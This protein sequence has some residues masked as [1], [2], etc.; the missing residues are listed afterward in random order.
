MTKSVFKKMLTL[1]ISAVFIKG[2]GFFFRIYLSKVAG[3]E[4]CGLYHLVLSV[5][6]LMA[7]VSS[8]GINQ[9]LSRLVAYNEKH[10]KRILK[11]ALIM[12]GIISTIVFLTVFLNARYIAIN[13]L[14]DS[15]VVKS[16][17]TVAFSFPAIAVFSSVAGY[18]NGLTKV[19]FASH[20]QII[21][22]IIRIIFVMLFLKKGMESGLD[23]GIL[24]LSFGIVLGEYISAM[25]I[26]ISYLIFS[27]NKKDAY[28]KRYF[29]KD[30]LKISI[31]VAS[32]GYISSFLH[33]VENILLREKLVLSGLTNSQS[34]SILGLAKGM[35]APIIFF[36]A[37]ITN[38][39]T[40]LTLPKISKEQ[41]LRNYK[42]IKRITKNALFI[43]SFTG[44]ISAVLFSLFADK[45][46]FFL[47]SN[48]DSV[49]F[50]KAMSLS[51]PFLFF[52]ITA[53]G[54][55][56]GMGKHF[57]VMGEN[58]FISLTKLLSI[59][60]LV[61]KIG[62]KGYFFGFVFSEFLGFV[63]YFMLIY[64]YIYKKY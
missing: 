59:I 47:Y 37:L 1:I 40:I 64:N 8:F 43:C 45:I 39:V 46:C 23:S 49:I 60:F 14:K 7:S 10:S 35:A 25:Y 22:Q 21:E 63:M 31:P 18:F 13:I 6:A 2:L 3:A 61:A 56:N 27:K 55:L 34:V 44:V 28:T 17:K 58:V 57:I 62:I 30:I 42:N 26:F 54:I 15:R 12:T 16:V 29:I 48:Y 11:T 20:G 38:A 50:V 4:G 41:S 9:T 24:V 53:S 5:Y 33:T 52:N 51:L 32:G 36:P 19:K